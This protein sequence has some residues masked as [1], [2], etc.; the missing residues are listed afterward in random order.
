LKSVVKTHLMPELNVG[1]GFRSSG[2]LSGI[3]W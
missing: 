3:C 1:K 2:I